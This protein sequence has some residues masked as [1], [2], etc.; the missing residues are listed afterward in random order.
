MGN[1]KLGI[2]VIGSGRAGM[3]HARNFARGVK[4]AKLVAMVDPVEDAATAAVQELELDTY[5]LSYKDALKNESINVVVV[6]TPTVYHRDIVVEAAEA[7]KHI[8]CEKPMAMN[9]R[10]CEEMNA[11]AAKAKVKLQ[12]GF[13]R[14]FDRN[15]IQAKEYIDSGAIGEVVLVKSLTRGPSKPRPWMFDIKKSNGPL[16]EVSSHDIDTL[17]WF[18]GSEFEHVYAIAGNYRN[19][20]VKEEFPDFYD[21][22]IMNVRFENQRQGIVDGAVYV[23]YGYDARVEV[24][25]TEGVLFVG[26]LE[27]SSAVYCKSSNQM[28]KPVTKS[29]RNLFIDA[30]EAEDVQFIQAIL[31]DTPAP[32]TGIDG[33]M[34]VKAVNAGN[35]SIIEKRPVRM[36]EDL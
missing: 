10:E 14:R 11:A 17:R 6:V 9:V 25:G 30:Y 29:W 23:Q 31:E 21:N 1:G 5:Y 33:M 3:I 36:G 35:R 19:P 28:V 4:G 18:M 8:L 27:D 20:E 34:A 12:I 32:V 7:G 26:Q 2:A 24:L 13:M 22:V 15:F 16:A